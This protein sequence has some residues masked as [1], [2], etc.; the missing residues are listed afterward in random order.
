MTDLPAALRYLEGR[1]AGGSGGL[2]ALL[3]SGRPDAENGSPGP[4]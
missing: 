4:P 2:G 3:S 1:R